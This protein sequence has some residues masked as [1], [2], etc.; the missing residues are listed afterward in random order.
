M[1]TIDLVLET[2][3]AVRELRSDSCDADTIDGQIVLAL[4]L[5]SWG[6]LIHAARFLEGQP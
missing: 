2:V 5:L 6:Y 4:V 3:R 1:R